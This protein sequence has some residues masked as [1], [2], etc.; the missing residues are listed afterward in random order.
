VPAGSA[1]NLFWR[2]GVAGN[3]NTWDVAT[4]TNWWTGTNLD[5]F[6]QGDSVT[7][8]DSATTTTV[9]MATLVKP[10]LMTNNSTATYVLNGSG[11]LRAAALVANSQQRHLHHR[12]QQ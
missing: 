2:G 6:S 10:G 4:T 3:P 9:T 1:G 5:K 8:D 12:Q 11:S 7:F